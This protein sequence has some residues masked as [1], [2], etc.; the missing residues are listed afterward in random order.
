[1]K[2]TLTLD[3]LNRKAAIKQ[4]FLCVT[5]AQGINLEGEARQE[6]PSLFFQDL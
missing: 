3:S 4:S 1:M 5:Q 6:N 2:Q